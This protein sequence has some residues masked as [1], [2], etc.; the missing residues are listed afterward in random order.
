MASVLVTGS[1][2][3]LGLEWVRTRMGGEGTSLLP[4][5]SVRGMR[6]LVEKFTLAQSGRFFRYDGLK[7]PW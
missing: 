4:P 6:S 2:R 1:N 7:M 3:G 5:E